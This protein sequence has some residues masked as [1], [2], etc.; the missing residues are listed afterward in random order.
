MKKTKNFDIKIYELEQKAKT[1]LLILIVFI[2]SFLLGYWCKNI[3]YEDML[4]KQKII[5]IDLKEQ[6]DR[7]NQ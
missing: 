1:F 7:A 6:I 3:E 5:I 2:L 4:Y